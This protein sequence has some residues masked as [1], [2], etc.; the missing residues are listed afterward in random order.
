LE[1]LGA[2][3]WSVHSTELLLLAW[4]ALQMTQWRLLKQQLGSAE[5]RRLDS[6]HW[7]YRLFYHGAREHPDGRAPIHDWVGVPA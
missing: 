2:S 3:R 4:M 1:W 5:R 7:F 6:D